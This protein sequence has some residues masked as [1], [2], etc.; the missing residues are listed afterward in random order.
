MLRKVI[1]PTKKQSDGA[2]AERL[3]EQF[4]VQQGYQLIDR[5][6]HCRAGELDLI[7]RSPC[8][9]SIVFIEVRYRAS[10]ARG[11]ASETITRQKFQRCLKSAEF[12]LMKHNLQ[13]SQ[14]Q[15]DVI[16]I[17]GELSQSN[18]HWL[19]AVQV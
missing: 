12:W 5:N 8:R 1:S 9:Q 7:M 17:D 4:L 19:Q 10:K 2:K 6:V 15:I 3:A 18:I 13:Q 14:Y 16:A 11:S